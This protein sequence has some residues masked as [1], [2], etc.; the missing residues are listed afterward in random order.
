MTADQLKTLTTD[1]LDTL[2]TSSADQRSAS[3]V[4]LTRNLLWDDPDWRLLALEFDVAP[5]AA[6]QSA[7][8][9]RSLIALALT[10]LMSFTS[11]PLRVVSVLGFLTF[12]L[13]IGVGADALL[14]WA[15]GRSVSGFATLII[16]LLLIGSFIMISLGV[17][18]E[19]IAKIYDEIKQRPTYI[20]ERRHEVDVQSPRADEG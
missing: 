19:Y 16:S 10:A 13:G 5:R 14:S 12:L 20:V 3:F 4:D 11:V 1:A 2:A 17:I 18:G 9:V 7:W 8:R 6:G 15:R